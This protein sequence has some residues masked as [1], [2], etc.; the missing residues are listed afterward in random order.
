MRGHGHSVGK[1]P[2]VHEAISHAEHEFTWL[3]GMIF[4]TVKDPDNLR[5]AQAFPNLGG[6]L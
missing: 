2:T 1:A 4:C 6:S 3:S 5:P